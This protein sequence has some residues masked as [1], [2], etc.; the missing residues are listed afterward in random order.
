MLLNDEKAVWCVF[1]CHIK[2]NPYLRIHKTM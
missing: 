1:A 2:R